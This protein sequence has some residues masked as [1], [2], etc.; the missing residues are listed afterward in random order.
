MRKNCK[1][2]QIHAYVCICIR[3]IYVYMLD[4]YAY[5]IGV[6]SMNLKSMEENK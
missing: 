4:M 6:P 5:G 3:N 1:R 2:S